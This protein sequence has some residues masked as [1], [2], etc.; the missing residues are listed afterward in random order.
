MLWEQKAVVGTLFI[1][2]LLQERGKKATYRTRYQQIMRPLNLFLVLIFT[3]NVVF[4]PA[5][6]FQ[7]KKISFLLLVLLNI[8]CFLVL[9]SD[10]KKILFAAGVWLTS[11]MILK[12]MVLTGNIVQEFAMGLSGYMVLLYFITDRYRID[13]GRIL[14]ITLVV[15]ASFMCMNAILDFI[16]VLPTMENPVLLYLY[17]TDNALVGRGMQHS[18]GIIYFMKAS[19]LLLLTI[20][21]LWQKKQYLWLIPVCGALVLSG[22]RANAMIMVVTVMVTCFFS[23]KS[24]KTRGILVVLGLAAFGV[25]VWKFDLIGRI[26]NVFEMKQ[27]NDTIRDLTLSSMFSYWKD[28]PLNLIFGSGFSSFFYNEGRQALVNNVELSYW[29]LFRQIG[30]IPF[31]ALM[32]AYIYPLFRLKPGMRLMTVGYLAYLVVAYTNPLLYSSTGVMAVL[33]MYYLIGNEQ[34]GRNSL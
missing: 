25:L 19:P 2:D 6:T 1:G 29:N 14:M 32:G 17:H 34:N 12:S 3:I 33:F 27:D 20:P 5:D 4:F 11:Y 31:L 30:L 9:D 7:A 18:F 10:E 22:T 15:L 23:L 26:R 28:H 24:W 21:Y 8:P 13:L 16:G